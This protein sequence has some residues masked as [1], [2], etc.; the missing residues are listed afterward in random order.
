MPRQAHAAPFVLGFMMGTA[1]IHIAGV[2]LGLTVSK[3][4][5]GQRLV[6]YAGDAIATTGIGFLASGIASIGFLT[7]FD[8]PFYS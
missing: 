7:S 6:R 1:V 5:Q 4:A 2:V 8:D 3:T